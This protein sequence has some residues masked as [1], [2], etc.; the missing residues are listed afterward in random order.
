MLMKAIFPSMALGAN[1]ADF[2]GA[3][4]PIAIIDEYEVQGDQLEA[5]LDLHHTVVTQGWKKSSDFIK[6]DSIDF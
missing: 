1:V 6:Y 4:K 2:L 3:G 5:F